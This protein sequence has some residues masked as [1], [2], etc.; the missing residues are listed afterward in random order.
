M[1]WKV[2]LQFLAAIIIIGI[3]GNFINTAVM[4]YYFYVASNGSNVGKMMTAFN[5][6]SIDVRKVVGQIKLKD[7][8]PDITQEAITL[9]N[10]NK[11]W[12]QIIDKS[13]KEIESVNK[14]VIV[15]SQYTKEDLT[16][17]KDAP[18]LLK[19][20]DVFVYQAPPSLESMTISKFAVRKMND[21]TV[22]VNETEEGA[23]PKVQ[24]IIGVPKPKI[25]MYT[26][27]YGFYSY[28]KGFFNIGPTMVSNTLTFMIIILLGYIFARRLTKPVVK[29]TDGIAAMAEGDLSISY[30]EKGLYKEVY[31]SLNHMS[32]KLQSN[33]LERKKIEK[34][35]EEWIAN[36][37]HDLKTPLSSIRGYIELMLEA[38][39]RVTPEERIK[40]SKIIMD[41]SEY[42]E[43][44]LEDLKLTQKLKNELIPLNKEE[45]NVVELLR[46]VVINILNDPEYEERRVIFEPQLETV[47]LN[48]DQ[49]LMQRAFTNIVCNAMI[50]NPEETMVWVRVMKG[51]GIRIE[52]E[53]NGR[54]IH[55]DDQENLFERY[56]RGTNTE[57]SRAGS[58]LGLAISKQ[59]IEAHG[60][61]IRLESKIGE[62]TKVEILFD[63]Q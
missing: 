42:M 7:E 55:K 47:M 45:V 28:I 5:P 58:G 53:D 30:T 32:Q 21:G 54:G 62:G 11:S 38:D 16:K 33:E 41:K 1:R 15:K 40:F 51:K 20:Y 61:K 18:G 37:S 23:M 59:I 22:P 4:S 9:L 46:E 34:M 14:P 6:N 60:G 52:I 10:E 43:V 27:L 25:T 2:T 13:G 35:R 8:Q 12:V 56:Y 50:H 29:I 19:G 17:L 31:T 24:Y 3:A 39:D 36:I 26:F 63:M 44:L 48:A 57:E 49:V